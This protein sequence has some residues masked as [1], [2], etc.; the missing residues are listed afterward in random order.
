MKDLFSSHIDLMI[1]VA[2]LPADEYIILG[3]IIDSKGRKLGSKDAFFRK[4]E[5]VEW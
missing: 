5:G 4:V 2:N 3:E 1:N